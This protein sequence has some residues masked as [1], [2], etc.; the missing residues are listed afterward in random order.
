M[1]V[2]FNLGDDTESKLLTG[3]A[4]PGPL[5]VGD[6][7]NNFIPGP[8]ALCLLHNKSSQE[9][10]AL[11][12]QRQTPTIIFISGFYI[13]VRTCQRVGRNI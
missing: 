3:L 13:P 7:S 11:Y 5:A 12:V 9:V 8:L 6:T 10:D 1:T 4:S 2:H